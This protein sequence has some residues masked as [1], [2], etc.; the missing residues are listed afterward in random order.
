M[1]TIYPDFGHEFKGQI[2]QKNVLYKNLWKIAHFLTSLH[3]QNIAKL[4]QP[5]MSV[6]AV[7]TA[8]VLTY[9]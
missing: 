3:L 4:L 9:V 5:T 7:Y 6:R 2:T 8:L 1:E